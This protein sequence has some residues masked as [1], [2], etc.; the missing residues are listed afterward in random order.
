M[1]NRVAKLWSRLHEIMDKVAEL[2]TPSRIASKRSNYV[3]VSGEDWRGIQETDHLL[4]VPG[5]RRSIRAG[6]AEPLDR[7]STN[8]GW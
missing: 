8:P 4:S 3:P 7:T 2:R 5:L 6:M 1:T